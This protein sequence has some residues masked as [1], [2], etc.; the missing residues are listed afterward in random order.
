MNASVAKVMA[1]V[2]AVRARHS[3]FNFR[4]CSLRTF[5]YWNSFRSAL[6]ISGNV[7]AGYHQQA[8]NNTFHLRHVGPKVTDKK[9]ACVEVRRKRVFLLRCILHLKSASFC[10]DRLGTSIGKPLKK[11]VAFSNR[12]SLKS[13]Q[14]PRAVSSRSIY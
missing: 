2:G 3:S 11:R 1:E 4:N 7:F 5:N 6:L 10:Q 9:G 14:H 12:A 8:I 13:A